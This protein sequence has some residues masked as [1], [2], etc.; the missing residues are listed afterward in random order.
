MLADGY[1][2]ISVAQRCNEVR[3][4]IEVWRQGDQF[5]EIAGGLLPAVEL[6][7]RWRANVFAGMSTARTSFRRE[8]R[9]FN[10]GA[11]DQMLEWGIELP[12]CGDRAEAGY[13]LL[14]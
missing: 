2:D 5:D 11:G 7:D 6:G 3:R 8:V 12:R 13:Y 4:S 1:E 14:F 9:A 10:M